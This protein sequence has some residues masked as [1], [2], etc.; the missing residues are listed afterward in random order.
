MQRS[1]PS[2]PSVSLPPP[3]SASLL[4]LFPSF[5]FLFLLSRLF[6]PSLLSPHP[7]PQICLDGRVS[8]DYSDFFVA[9]LQ[10]CAIEQQENLFKAFSVY[11][12]DLSGY[13]S[14]DELKRACDKY[15]VNKVVVMEM[16]REVAR[17]A[18]SGG[19]GDGGRDA[20]G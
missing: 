5:L 16:M 20:F 17:D 15:R 10:L 13:I 18:V 11:D 19:W 8:F 7:P 14:A 9:V 4:S 3:S 12:Q 6:L 1:Y 2:S